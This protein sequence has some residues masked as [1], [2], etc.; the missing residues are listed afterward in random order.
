MWSS[1]SQLLLIGTVTVNQATEQPL[2]YL[3]TGVSLPLMP[4]DTPELFF[5][6]SAGA[7]ADA[8]FALE[9]PTIRVLQGG[10]PFAIPEYYG[11][12]S[13]VLDTVR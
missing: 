6:T 4:L 11:E 1:A 10:R 12:S 3:Q 8:I 5:L 9:K 13:A 2:D 7:L